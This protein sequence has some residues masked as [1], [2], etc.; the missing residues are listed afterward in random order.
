M[1]P[2]EE[3]R[4][5]INLPGP[6]TRRAAVSGGARGIG[7][8]AL[9]LARTHRDVAVGDVRTGA[10]EV[11]AEVAALGRRR[12][13]RPR[14]HRRRPPWRP[15]PKRVEHRLGPVDVLVNCAGWDEFRSFLDTDEEFWRR[16]IAINYEG[17]LRTTKALLGG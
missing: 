11:A 16:V 5:V 1:A 8:A 15:P 2:E 6:W 9:A 17:A 7:R 12:G 3:L 10:A 4:A 14:R 13:G